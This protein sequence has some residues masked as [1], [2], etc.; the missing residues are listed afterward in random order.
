L[1]FNFGFRLDRE[2]F[3]NDEIEVPTNPLAPEIMPGFTQPRVNV[4]VVIWSFS[5]RLGLTF[6]LTGDGKTILR[7]NLA[8][9]GQWPNDLADI[10][11]VTDENIAVYYWDDQNGD[12]FVSTD[13]LVGYPYEGLIY[14]SGYNPF[15]PKNPVSPN[16]IEK[17]IPQGVTD[18]LLFG[19]EREIFKDFSL[20]ANITLRKFHHWYR[21]TYYNRET[22][23]RD[24]RED[25]GDPIQGSL[26][27]DGKTYDYEYWAPETHRFDLPNRIFEGRPNY[28][29]NYVGFEIIATKRLSNRWMMNA[30]FTIQ[31]NIEYYEK[32]SYFDPTNIKHYDGGSVFNDSRWMAKINFLYQLPWGFNFSGFAHAREG[33]PAWQYIQV[34]APEREA[35]G[36]GSYVNVGVEKYGK[37]RLP[38]FYNIDLSLSK[39]FMLGQY[40]RLTIQVDAFNVFNFSHTL[41]RNSRLN[42]PHYNEIQSILNPRVIRFGIR[43][44]F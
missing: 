3:W 8:R 35:K 42:S 33:I 28:G 20:N 25:W 43:Y 4:D 12:D 18:E 2:S 40:G 27:A 16:D 44:K 21:W 31:Q 15:D 1:T 10:M 29:G 11:S 6:D 34:Y 19:V 26:T 22:G 24:N 32:G 14:Y 5:P 37:T 7:A 41:S 39:D 36:W 13:E 17:D 9:Y 30:S 38:N 23:K